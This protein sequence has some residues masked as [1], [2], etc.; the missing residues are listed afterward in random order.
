MGARAFQRRIFDKKHLQFESFLG[1]HDPLD[2]PFGQ[3]LLPSNLSMAL[4]FLVSAL[5]LSCKFLT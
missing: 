5:H 4:M 1:L 2:D 3:G